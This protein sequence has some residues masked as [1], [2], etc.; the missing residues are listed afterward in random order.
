MKIKLMA[1]ALLF[2]M[3]LPLAVSCK[4]GDSEETT[5]AETTE[6]VGESLE[7]KILIAENGA[8]L[9]K[10]IRSEYVDSAFYSQCVEFT[11]KIK[12]DTGAAFSATDDFV[13]SGT[14]TSAPLEILFGST[15]RAEC[16]ELYASISYDGYAVKNIGNKI[17]IAAYKGDVMENAVK[18]FFEECIEITEE[19][20]VKKVYYVKNVTCEG[21]EKPFFNVDNPISEY[22]LIYSKDVEIAA[23]AFAK[24][25][26]TYTNM[27]IEILP[28]STA[29]S[30]KEI[31]FGNTNRPESKVNGEITGGEFII[32]TAGSKV[33]ICAG[34]SVDI[35]DIVNILASSYMKT[36]P[37]FNFPASLKYVR[38]MFVSSDRTELSEGA[39]FRVM[40]F[41]ILSEEWAE[42][43]KDI[44]GRTAGVVECIKAY[45]PDVVGVQE[46]SVKWYTILKRELGD[47][48][49]FVNTDAA[50]KTNGCYTGLAYRKSTV[51]L[52]EK[53]LTY[54][55]VYN[56]KRLRLINMGLFELKESGKR[57][58]VTDTHF[59]ANHKDAETENKNRIQQAKEF[60]AK[61]DEYRKKYNC[62]IIMTGDYNSSES[63]DAYKVIASDKL[64]TETKYTALTKGKIYSTTHGVGSAPGEA[65]NSID[66]IFVTGAATPVYYTTVIDNYVVK[67]SDHSPIFCDFKFD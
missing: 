53:D 14:D 39:D 34:K 31:L 11:K 17:V 56:N 50:G 12:E 43:A 62:P 51:K 35:N 27:D 41:N 23:K 1:F 45:A 16:K 24:R 25:M 59:N 29:V 66:H 55:T 9:Y 33:V 49:T 58:I 52:I 40:S 44:E 2:I 4:N 13:R 63:S 7:N 48:Y 21:T 28:D 36:S 32:K 19:D 5:P 6:P 38:N 60:I 57:F 26:S 8:A 18:A 54:Y 47:E 46:V 10:I 3:V 30:D 64:I 67:V 42:E 37:D 15:N 22:K 20:G 65:T 61:I